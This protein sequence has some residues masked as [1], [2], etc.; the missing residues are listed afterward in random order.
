LRQLA[1]TYEYVRAELIMQDMLRYSPSEWSD[2]SS[3]R[4]HA[5][6]MVR[7]HV[8]HFVFGM[9][10]DLLLLSVAAAAHHHHHHNHHHD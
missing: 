9:D 3:E 1:I 6:E 4:H 8:R 2:L 5:M 7:Q 10:M